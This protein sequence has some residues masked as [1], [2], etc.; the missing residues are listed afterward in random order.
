MSSSQIVFVQSFDVPAAIGWAEIGQQNNR[1]WIS[2][3]RAL[4]TSGTAR[5]S[6]TAVDAA[7]ERPFTLPSIH[8]YF[9]TSFRPRP[10]SLAVAPETG[11]SISGSGN[12]S[13]F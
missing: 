9:S 6:F 8:K 2:E 7:Y 12:R 13:T 5:K 11:S 1:Q 3:S 4:T 10:T